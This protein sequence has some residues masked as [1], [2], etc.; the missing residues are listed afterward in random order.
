MTGRASSTNSYRFPRVA[1]ADW[2]AFPVGVFKASTVFFRDTAELRRRRIDV[3]H[4]YYYG[5][6]GTPTT[7]ALVDRVREIEGARQCLLAPSGLAALAIVNAALLEAGDEVLVPH[8]LYSYNR[9]LLRHFLPKWS[10]T[11]RVYDPLD[12]RALGAMIGPATKLVWIEAAGSVTLE[13]PDLRG[14]IRECRERDVVTALDNT[15]GAGIS[16]RP[17]DVGDGLGVDISV[18]AL[19]KYASGGADVLMGSVATNS[20]SLFRDLREANLYLGY[21]VGANDA[22]LVLR[23]LPSMRHRY[24]LQDRSTL[25]LARWM[26]TLPQVQRV[27]HPALEGSPGHAYWKQTCRGSACLFTAVLRERYGREQ[28]DAFVDSLRLYRIGLSWAGPMSLAVPYDGQPED[29]SQVGLYG[30]NLVRFAQGLEDVEDLQ[31]D[32]EQALTVLSR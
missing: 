11:Y 4:G 16:F 23:G 14:L 1:V 18:Q 22:E 17:F 13:F 5:L 10:A 27:L 8:N 31:A 32:I 28:V 29:E 15:W 30:T 21:G 12:S 2:D 20:E 26:Q 9:D 24:E 19:T 6:H 7:R 3:G 25:A